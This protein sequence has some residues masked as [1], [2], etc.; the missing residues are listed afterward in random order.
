MKNWKEFGGSVR[1]LNEVLSSRQGITIPGVPAR[2]GTQHLPD[3]IQKRHCLDHQFSP[4]LSFTGLDDTSDNNNAK[5]PMYISVNLLGNTVIC[6]CHVT[7]LMCILLCRFYVMIY[8]D[9]LSY[10]EVLSYVKQ[11]LDN[12]I[13]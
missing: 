2:T 12:L 4:F 8:I 13:P 7:D 11:Y 10:V 5:R 6:M 1:G 3:T 9:L